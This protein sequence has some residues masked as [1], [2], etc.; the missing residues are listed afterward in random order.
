MKAITSQKQIPRIAHQKCSASQSK[1]FMSLFKRSLRAR[2]FRVRMSAQVVRATFKKVGLDLRG[3]KS[4]DQSARGKN[5]K[6]INS[7]SLPRFSLGHSER[8]PSVPSIIEIAMRA[9]NM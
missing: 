9:K 8:K 2:Q 6:S 5:A 4:G 3:M 7:M 1:P